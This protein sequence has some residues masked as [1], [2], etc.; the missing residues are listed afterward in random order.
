[1]RTISSYLGLDCGETYCRRF[2]YRERIACH[3]SRHLR[4]LRVACVTVS[5]GFTEL[6][7][8]DSYLPSSKA[9]VGNK[10]LLVPSGE[11]TM[12]LMTSWAC[13]VCMSC[14]ICRFSIMWIHCCRPWWQ[15]PDRLT[16]H[17]SSG[18]DPNSWHCVSSEG[19]PGIVE[20]CRSIYQ[21]E[22]WDTAAESASTN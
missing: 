20:V 3:V 4:N 14:L 12:M 22:D 5:I 8:L 2:S 7:Q 11:H 10:M 16:I 19:C 1:M 18:H 15:R 13:L 9:G 21:G 6:S 17:Q